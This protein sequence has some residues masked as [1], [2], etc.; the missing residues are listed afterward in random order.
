MTRKPITLTADIDI[1][2]AIA[3]FNRHRVSCIPIVGNEQ[4]IQGILSWRDILQALEKM[5]K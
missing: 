2:E 3:I 5:R 1:Y 4:H